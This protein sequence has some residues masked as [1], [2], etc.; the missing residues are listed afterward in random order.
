[1]GDG[2]EFTSKDFKKASKSN[3]EDFM[4][5]YTLW[6]D[7]VIGEAKKYNFYEDISK[8]KYLLYS[9]LGLIIFVIN[10]IYSDS[11]PNLCI[12]LISL[13]TAIISL[14][15]IST[16]FK[17]SRYGAEEYAKN[18]GLKNF[19]LEFGNM[20]DKELPEVYLWEKYLVFA[21]SLGIAD[22]V[23][24]VFKVKLQNMNDNDMSYP[25]YPILY[26]YHMGIG[27]NLATTINSSISGAISTATAANTANSSGSG[28]GGGA[29][30]GGGGGGF[31]GG[32]GRG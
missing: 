32:G 31:G 26:C 11:L 14:I 15:T 4:S 19:M 5:S 22:K 7:D 10:I 27:N 1:M 25:D 8:G 17:R 6:K 24:N 9:F 13:F 3:Y 2:V 30:F 28:F 12:A 18:Q 21:T 16:S 20:S 23:Q 29:S